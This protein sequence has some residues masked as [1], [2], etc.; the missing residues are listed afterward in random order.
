MYFEIK[1]CESSDGDYIVD[2][3]VKYNLSKVPKTQE[4]DFIDVN[5]RDYL[6]NNDEK[7]KE[8]S[9]LKMRLAEEYSGDR[10][11]YTEGKN[12]FIE[13]VLCEAAKWRKEQV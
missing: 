12:T 3:L 4:I 13:S 5:M 11:A 10:I 8:Y 6:N 2:G 9:E 1:D 7:A